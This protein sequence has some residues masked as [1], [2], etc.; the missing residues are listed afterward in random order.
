MT[1][2]AKSTDKGTTPHTPAPA[3][4]DP[5]EGGRETVERQLG[6]T[7]RG[8]Q[9]GGYHPENRKGADEATADN[10]LTTGHSTPGDGGDD[11]AKPG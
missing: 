4:K 9:Q 5:A 3:G 2:T 6:R 7:E 10:D 1:D 8:G 11:N